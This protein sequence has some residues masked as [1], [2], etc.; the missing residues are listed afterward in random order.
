MPLVLTGFAVQMTSRG[1]RAPA[2]RVFQEWHFHGPHDFQTPER[3]L[4]A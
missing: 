3:V 1:A 2:A 4:A